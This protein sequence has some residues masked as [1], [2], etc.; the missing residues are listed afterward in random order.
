MPVKHDF[1]D[2][3][4][5]LTTKNPNKVK[6][7]GFSGDKFNSPEKK[8][9]GEILEQSTIVEPSGQKTA[10]RLSILEEAKSI[11]HVTISLNESHADSLVKGTGSATVAWIY[12][13]Y[14]HLMEPHLP[15]LADIDRAVL[16]SNLTYPD[17]FE[18]YVDGTRYVRPKPTPM[19]KELEVQ[20]K[21]VKAKSN[22]SVKRKVRIL[23]MIVVL[24]IM[25]ALIWMYR[26]PL[27]SY[28]PSGSLEANFRIL[29]DDSPTLTDL[30]DGHQFG[31]DQKVELGMELSDT[32]KP[33][34]VGLYAIKSN[35]GAADLRMSFILQPGPA[36]PIKFVVKDMLNKPYGTIGVYLIGCKLKCEMILPLLSQQIRFPPDTVHLV[37]REKIRLESS[38]KYLLKL[39]ALWSP[40]EID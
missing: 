31:P 18:Q 20:K 8:L 28:S 19:N 15:G 35:Q 40:N 29:Q 2:F 30:L 11:C 1:E 17:C 23:T 34:V 27:F 33:A 21:S 7:T 36:Q 6:F 3:K 5:K 9:L 24:L 22:N 26:L 13:Y 12:Y 14:L 16:G 39:D 38:R 32:A 10:K 37:Y 25:M 4:K